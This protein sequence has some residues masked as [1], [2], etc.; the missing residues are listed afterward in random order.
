LR[1]P[2]AIVVVPTLSAGFTLWECVESLQTQLFLDFLIVIVDNSGARL[3]EQTWPALLSRH[4]V[5]ILHPASNLGF[6][7][8]VNLATRQFNSDFVAVL[9]DDATADPSFLSALVD[10]LDANPAA[11][12]AAAQVRLSGAP[13]PQ[14]DSAAMLIA[15]DGTSKQRGHG[16]PPDSFP[17]PEEALLPSGS[18]ALYRRAMLD[19]TGGFDDDFFLYCEDTDLGLRARWAGWSARYVPAAV[20]H[21][22]Y[23]HSVGRASKLKAYYVERNRLRTILKNFPAPLLLRAFL[24]TPLRYLFHLAAMR[25]GRGAAAQFQQQGGSPFT[26]VACVVKAHLDAVAHLPHLLRQRRAIRRSA[27]LSPDAFSATLRRFSISLREVA[28]L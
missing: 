17:N 24:A 15:A 3:V 28:A 21:H 9:N 18:A 14:L 23:S 7:A 11:G 27:R 8:A 26:L 12:S 5:A 2:R 13:S 4:R 19:Q 16:A 25:A 1:P 22:R 20:V 6:G 10:D